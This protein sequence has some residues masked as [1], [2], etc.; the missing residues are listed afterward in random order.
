MDHISSIVEGYIQ[1]SKTLMIGIET[2]DETLH[3]ASYTGS[4]A[5]NVSQGGFSIKIMVC[6]GAFSGSILNLPWNRENDSINIQ[7]A[8]NISPKKRGI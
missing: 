3:K 6:N 8:V 7:L 5:Q 2:L 4:V 1:H